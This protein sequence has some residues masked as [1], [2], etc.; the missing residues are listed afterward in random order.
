MVPLYMKVGKG[1]ISPFKITKVGG[2]INGLDDDKLAPQEA[3]CTTQMPYI[4]WKIFTKIFGGQI[5]AKQPKDKR[6]PRHRL[7]YRKLMQLYLVAFTPKAHVPMG[8]SFDGW[9]RL[10][11]Q[12]IW[13]TAFC[14]MAK[15]TKGPPVLG[16]H[17]GNILCLNYITQPFTPSCFGEP[18]VIL[19]PLDAAYLVAF[20]P[21]AHG[22]MGV[23]FDG[24]HR[25][26]KQLYAKW[27][28]GQMVPQSQAIIQETYS[29][30]TTSHNH[31]HLLILGNQK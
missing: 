23:S 17:T 20:T 30:S 13:R 3:T 18:G 26:P 12:D 31:S 15:G 5:Y 24:W 1:N 7:S 21:K 11:K 4:P 19:S 9:H 10:S 6:S 2:T 29:A 22:P 28:K 8:V 14:Q 27:P 25:L 16:Y